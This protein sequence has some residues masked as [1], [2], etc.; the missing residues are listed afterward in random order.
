MAATGLAAGATVDTVTG[1]QVQALLWKLR[2]LA[3]I[4]PRLPTMELADPVYF[5]AKKEGTGK[6]VLQEVSI[7]GHLQRIG[8]LA[9]RTTVAVELGA[10]AAR[11]SDRLG[12]ATQGRLAHVLVDRK[13]EEDSKSRDKPMRTRGARLERIV[14]DIADFDFAGGCCQ[15]CVSKHL[16]GPASDLAIAAIGRA[17]AAGSA[18]AGVGS[19]GGGGPPPSCLATCCH[20]LCSWATYEGREFWLAAGLT[21]SDFGV[22][23]SVSQWNSMRKLTKQPQQAQGQSNDSRGRAAGLSAGDLLGAPT[24]EEHSCWLPDMAQVAE[25]ANRTLSSAGG[26]A[27]PPAPASFEAFGKEF[28]A[29]FSRAEKAALGRQVKELLDLARCARLQRGLGYER[30]GLVR[31]TTRSLEDRLV[32]CQPRALLQAGPIL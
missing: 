23:V 12:R 27:G 5:D 29:S 18:A 24:D 10:G 28:E 31:Y 7:I 14:G 13:G 32:V 15:L 1:A 11:L 9:P 4:L 19:G 8:A 20:Y 21:E 16:C 17:A 30:V 6:H 22:A 3:P 2:A 25:V 26:A